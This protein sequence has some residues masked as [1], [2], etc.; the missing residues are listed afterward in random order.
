VG[1][2]KECAQL[3]TDRRGSG[4]SFGLLADIRAAK[5]GPTW[6]EKCGHAAIPSTQNETA[7]KPD[8]PVKLSLLGG[9]PAA[10]AD[11]IQ[12]AYRKDQPRTTTRRDQ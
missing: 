7:F 4:T 9:H 8:A 5:N 10:R 1:D 3:F 11:R 12:P 6:K 2:G